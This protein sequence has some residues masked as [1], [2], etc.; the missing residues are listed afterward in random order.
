MRIEYTELMEKLGVGYALS[1]YETRPW[2]LH[3][4]EKGIMCSA[5]V[6]IGPNSSDVEAEIQFLHDDDTEPEPQPEPE[7][8]KKFNYMDIFENGKK[9]EEDE[10]EIAIE[11]KERAPKGPK[12]APDGPEQIFLM[13]LLPNIENQWQGAMLLVRGEPYHGKIHNWDERGAEFF[14]EFIAALQMNALPD[15]DEM[16]EEHLVDR[17]RYGR[18]GRRGRVGKKGFKVEQK[19]IKMNM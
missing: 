15:V 6:R 12:A 8:T 7:P 10:D 11:E 2:F 17:Q 16:I 9:E 3:D 14:C 18:R 13:R 19:G 1:A 4:S 5:E